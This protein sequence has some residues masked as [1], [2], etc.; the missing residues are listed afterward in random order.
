MNAWRA[1]HR[2]SVGVWPTAVVTLLATLIAVWAPAAV[3]APAAMSPALGVWAVPSATYPQEVYRLGA[4][5]PL[6][7]AD[8]KVSVTENGTPVQG[9]TVT[10]IGG[11]TGQKTGAVLLIDRSWSMNGAPDQSAIAAARAFVAQ[12][13]PN[14]PVAVIFFAETPI[15]AAPLTTNAQTLDRALSSVPKRQ[16][17]TLIM[18]AT[19]RAIGMLHAAGI[20]DG[21]VVILSDGQ[22]TGSKISESSLANLAQ[23]DNVHIYTFGMQDPSFDGST[24]QSLASESGG[25]YTPTNPTAV[26]AAY[27]QL[28]A[29]Q[30]NQYTVSYKTKLPLGSTVNLAVGAPGY[31]SAV[32]Q[33]STVSPKP[34]APKQSFINS[35]AAVILISVLVALLI[36]GAAY[37]IT[38][39]RNEVS[40]RVGEF[41]LPVT[42]GGGRE[43]ERSLVE[44]ALGDAQSRAGHKSPRVRAFAVELDVAGIAIAPVNYV[45]I[46]LIVMLIVGWFVVTAVGTILAA[47]AALIVPVVAWWLA[48]YLAD[49]QRR[50]FD[51]QL[52]DNLSVVASAMR[53]GQTFLGALQAVVDTAP[54]PSKRELRRAVTDAQLGVPIDEA[55]GALGER[56]KSADFQHVA[57]IAT[58]QRET[59]GNTAEVVE[60]VAETIR[61]RLELRQMV[62]AL[63]AQGRLAGLILSGLPVA[64]LILVSVI[65]PGYEHPLFHSTLGIIAL[66]AAG[67][68]TLFG[69][70]VLKRIVTI[71]I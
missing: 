28:G 36:G 21:T 67:V 55:L 32:T 61:E 68:L 41:V 59:G 8:P 66:V 50:L 17:G 44:L 3:A 70:Y 57:L 40:A 54:D 5:S 38:R 24:L 45:I 12:R 43:R 18:D 65:N 9:A 20:T 7:A 1:R 27:R 34:L 10:P 51:T 4:T 25:T 56:L 39:R 60:L 15:V 14:E 52:P 37:L 53:A 58:L 62:R 63:T 47:P 29:E 48:H 23:L 13:N 46:S 49:R 26:V 69:S 6:N 33:Y 71:E 19:H 42:G 64:L 30:A 11:S 16:S 22:D 2:W 31:P 35:T